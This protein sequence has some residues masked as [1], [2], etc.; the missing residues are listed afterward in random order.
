M[1]ASDALLDYISHVQV[2]ITQVDDPQGWVDGMAAQL[3]V[4][5][6][7]I[8]EAGWRGELQDDQVRDKLGRIETML[9]ELKRIAG[10]HGL[11]LTE[12]THARQQVDEELLRAQAEQMRSRV[13]ELLET[14]LSRRQLQLV[15][16]IRAHLKTVELELGIVEASR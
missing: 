9:E 3:L 7:S 1:P 6:W 13:E 14:H 16:G 5:S 2:R 12:K 4:E 11:E 15:N 10:E 8:K